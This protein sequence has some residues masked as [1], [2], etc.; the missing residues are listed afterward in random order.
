MR[1]RVSSE[2]DCSPSERSNRYGH[3]FFGCGGGGGAGGGD[4]GDAPVY[5]PAVRTGY[6][7]SAQ[8]RTHTIKCLLGKFFCN[9]ANRNF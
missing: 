1:S 5:A 7:L 4:T 3:C 8:S 2:V 6:V 9:V